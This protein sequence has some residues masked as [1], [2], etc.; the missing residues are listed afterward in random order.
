[1]NKT[2]F[3][4]L[5]SPTPAQPSE[6]TPRA[7]PRVRRP[8]R[9]QLELRPS[10]LESLLSPDHR[11]RIVWD[12][13]KGL[14]LSALYQKIL[15]VE[16]HSGR[17]PVDPAIYMA[18]WLYA[19]IE[20]IGSARALDRLCRQHDAYRWI[21]GGVSMNYHSLSDFRSAHADVLD[22]LLTQSTAALMSE[23]LVDL[24]R[25]SQD[26]VRVRASAGAASF[27]RKKTL[28]ECLEDAE[29]QVEALRKELKDDPGATSRRQ[30]AARE[31]ATRERK[32]RVNQALEQLPDVESKK[33]AKDKAKAR[34]ST[35]DP[36][37]RVMKMAD[38]G[39]RPA[40]NAQFAVDTAAQVVV[41]VDVS[42]LGSDQGKMPP[43]VD[44]IE[45]R[46]GE[47]PAEV[48][49]DGG[50][51]DHDSI[52]AVSGPEHD[53]TVYGPVPKPKDKNRDPYVALPGD[54]D[55]V[56]AWRERMGTKAAKEIYKE[57]ASTVECV[58]AIAR[59]RGLQRFLV[60]GQSKV[61]ATMLWFALAHNMM[62]GFTLRACVVNAT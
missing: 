29:T 53:C 6:P 52:D 22:D 9:A 62:R 8:N 35:T 32:E 37:A 7:A 5:P 50:Y 57:R 15:A 12:F 24:H 42:N 49:V 58:N 25:V 47:S 38:G 10:D 34:V 54:S 43:M 17:S 18:L 21:C 59:N 44:Q 45:D 1:M 14:D 61:R 13:V 39:F 28:K 2:L 46:Y 36:E 33:K 19:T 40:Y 56:A 60:R 30:Q 20:G 48:L 26:G 51:T 3:P 41:G 16:G 23:G 27:R 31:R 11:A 4:L 55:D